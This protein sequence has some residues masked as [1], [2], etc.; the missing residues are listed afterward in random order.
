MIKLSQ[1]VIVEGRYD[2]TT[3]ENIIDAL[4]IPTDGFRIFKDK[5]KCALIRS[6][7]QKNGIIIMTDS[8]SAGAMI[9]AH[10]KRITDN[11]NITHVYIPQ[12]IGKEKRKDKPSKEGTLGVEGMSAEII[13]E[14]LKKSGITG[15][16]TD[17][18]S[19]K[20]TKNDMFRFGL[21]GSPYAAEKRHSLLRFLE[22]PDNLSPNAML[23]IINT[24]FSYEE[25]E[26]KIDLWLQDT[27]KR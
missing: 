24:F 18:L 27:D 5:E 7:A 21:S 6:V 11:K 16:K 20:I 17:K 26:R 23:D 13:T 4:I 12:I 22:L 25:F 2:K 1:A 19:K 8:D 9:R 15:E 14:A 3:L 10:I